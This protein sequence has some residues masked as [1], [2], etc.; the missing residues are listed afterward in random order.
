M[1]EFKTSFEKR[2]PVMEKHF[3]SC[4]HFKIWP[5]RY[6]GSYDDYISVLREPKEE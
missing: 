5:T 1:H 2:R 4:E 6:L 3:A